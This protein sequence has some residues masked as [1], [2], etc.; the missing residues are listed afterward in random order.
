[1]IVLRMLV[2]Q[3]YK[4]DHPICYASQQLISMEQNYVIIEWIVLMT[5]FVIILFCHYF[6]GNKFTIVINH[7]TFKYLISKPNSTKIITRQIWLLQEYEFTINDQLR[8][9]YGN[10]DT[11]LWTYKLVG[12]HLKDDDFPNAKLFAFDVEKML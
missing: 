1:M 4:H 10:V 12:D 7:Q 2:L 6:L 5:I 11:L 3:S 8:K 9:K